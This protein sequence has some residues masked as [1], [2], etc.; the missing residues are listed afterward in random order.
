MEIALTIIFGVLGI[1]MAYPQSKLALHHLREREKG[2]VAV[3]ST[4]SKDPVATQSRIWKW[5]NANRPILT[6]FAIL[7]FVVCG[8]IVV[9]QAKNASGY[10]DIP[11][12][13][14]VKGTN[15]QDEEVVIDSIDYINC[16]FTHCKMKFLGERPCQFDDCYFSHCVWW[17]P[18]PEIR[19]F[20]LIAYHTG[21]LNTNAVVDLDRPNFDK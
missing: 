13:Q 8:T 17:S 11:P 10:K 3:T 14:I 19:D 16:N 21:L 12:T 20:M 9:Y 7:G 1:I 6:F 5:I 2:V 18:K 4:E 15:F